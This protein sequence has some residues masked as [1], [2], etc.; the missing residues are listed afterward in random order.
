VLDELRSGTAALS[1]LD[2]VLLRRITASQASALTAAMG[3][4]APDAAALTRLHGETVGVAVAG[5][6]SFALF[7]PTG[8]ERAA[9]SASLRGED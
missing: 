7:V 2:A 4:P 5:S 8:A 3:L 9:L 6:V 1:G